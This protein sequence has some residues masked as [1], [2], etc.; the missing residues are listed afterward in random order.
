LTLLGEVTPGRAKFSVGEYP[1]LDYGRVIPTSTIDSMET[2]LQTLIRVYPYLCKR[3][4]I[5]TTAF[6]C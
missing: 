3:Y 2:N 1:K 5:I 4:S 6:F